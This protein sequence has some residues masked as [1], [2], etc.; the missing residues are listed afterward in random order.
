MPRIPASVVVV[1]ALVLVPGARGED[2]PAR[3]SDG[4]IDELVAAHN[5][6]RAREDLGPLKPNSKLME[7]ARLHARD[8]AEHEKLSHEGSDGSTP[9]ERVKRQG[10]HYVSTGENVAEGQESVADVMKSWM[11]SP[12]HRRNV[13]GDFN[14]IG[15]SR[16]KDAEGRFYWVVDF[17]R[18]IPRLDPK[19]AVQAVIEQINQK[20]SEAG[21]PALKEVPALSEAAQAAA[22]GMARKDT[23]RGPGGGSTA[24]DMLRR[25]GYA[26]GEIRQSMASGY[27]DPESFVKSLTGSKDRD[28]MVFGDHTDVG[29]GYARAE[30]GTPYWVVLLASPVQG[31]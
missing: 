1:L 10:Y 14:E 21:K 25:E 9:A 12:G 6:E 22:Q 8:M 28:D 26:S 5:Q 23:I 29:V 19:K 11:N 2:G 16:A 27:A 17:G 4:L 3:S 13:L 18:A 7:A 24:F 20:R 31:R 15:A 30:D